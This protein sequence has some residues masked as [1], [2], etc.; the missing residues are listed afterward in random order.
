MIRAYTRIL[1]SY[2][3]FGGRTRRSEFWLFVLVQGAITVGALILSGSV[4][5]VVVLLLA[6]YLLGTLTPT[7]AAIVRRLHDTGRSS[8]WLLLG[9]GPAPVATGLIVAGLVFIQVGFVGE[10]FEFVGLAAGDPLA[11][12]AVETFEGLFVLGIA[13][14]SLG[15]LATFGGGVLAI[16]LLVL[17]AS[18]G[19]HGENKYGPQPD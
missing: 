5:D 6:L 9:L 1:K 2:M 13:L 16:V 12:D 18:P 3:A 11:E 14:F 8:W 15:V 7:L 4:H 17:L 10:I 19:Q